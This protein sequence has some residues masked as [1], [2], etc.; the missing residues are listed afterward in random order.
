MCINPVRITHLYAALTPGTTTSYSV[1]MN[2]GMGLQS[3]FSQEI[4]FI[5]KKKVHKF[6][7]DGNNHSFGTKMQCTL[8]PFY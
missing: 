3:L 5:Q 7:S 1:V 6:C 8:I 2:I 4:T